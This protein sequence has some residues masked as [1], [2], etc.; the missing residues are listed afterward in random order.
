MASIYK[1]SISGIRS[2]SDE[3]QETIQFGK[4]LTLIVG[5][6]GSGKT[7]IIECLRYATTGELPPGSKN[8]ASFIND[9]NLHSSNETKAQ[10]KLAFQNVKKVNM[11]LSKSLMATKNIRTKTI[12]FKSKENQLMTIRGVEKETISSKVADMESEIPK[13]LGVSKAILNYVIFCHQDDSLWPI[14]DSST[15]KKKFDE[16]FDSVK[17]IKILENIKQITKEL[18]VEIKLINNN[19][20]HLKNDRH[21]AHKK[22][23][24]IEDINNQ[25]N[26]FNK[27][28]EDIS[29]RITETDKE[30][31][32]LY[33]SNQ[34]FERVINVEQ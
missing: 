19:V 8:G 3:S 33:Q 5:T 13:L 25:I 2:F 32:K 15:L 27:D 34:D 17:F 22:M 24:S 31:N 20:V 21:R 18:N 29:T 1:L 28:V 12:S 6:N 23:S 9:P 26:K 11:I 30:L 4:P 7:T 14:S 16:I 10:V